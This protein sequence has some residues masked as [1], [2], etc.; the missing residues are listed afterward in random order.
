MSTNNVTWL[1]GF[2]LLQ[3]VLSLAYTNDW[4]HGVVYMWL[5]MKRVNISMWPDYLFILF[6]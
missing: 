6:S 5:Y 1:S 4:W 2:H 3:F